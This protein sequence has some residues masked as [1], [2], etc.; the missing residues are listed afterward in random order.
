MN[1]VTGQYG[2]NAAFGN[3]TSAAMEHYVNYGYSE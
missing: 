1:G 3:D 2:F